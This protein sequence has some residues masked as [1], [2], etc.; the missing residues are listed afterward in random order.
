MLLGELYAEGK[1]VQ[2]SYELAIPW[3][4]K[5]VEMLHDELVDLRRGKQWNEKFAEQESELQK[6]L[7]EIKTRLAPCYYRQATPAGLTDKQAHVWHK[8]AA[9]NGRAQSQY[10]LAKHTYAVLNLSQ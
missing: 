1:G 6:R 3:Y 10:W 7:T 9:E 4:E 5:K 2:Q 8:K